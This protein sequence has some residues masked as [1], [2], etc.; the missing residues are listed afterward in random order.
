MNSIKHK[1]IG[2]FAAIAVASYTIVVPSELEKMI[3]N[4]NQQLSQASEAQQKITK[5]MDA[6]E[7]VRD[8]GGDVSKFSQEVGIDRPSALNQ[9]IDTAHIQKQNA[10]QLQKNIL[11]KL[12]NQK[13]QE[14]LYTPLLSQGPLNKEKTS[15]EQA[16]TNTQTDIAHE[17]NSYNTTLT[18]NA[19]FN[20]RDIKLAGSSA[21]P[22][23]GPI[24]PKMPFAKK[25]TT[26]PKTENSTNEFRWIPTWM[27]TGKQVLLT[28]A[29]AGAGYAAWKYI[30][31]AMRDR[32]SF[33]PPSKVPTNAQG[34]YLYTMRVTHGDW[35]YELSMPN[36]EIKVI[37][38]NMPAYYTQLRIMN[39]GVAEPIPVFNRL[40]TFIFDQKMFKGKDYAPDKAI[41]NFITNEDR[42]VGNDQ[43]EITIEGTLGV[44]TKF[45]VSPKTITFDPTN[46]Q[47]IDS[48]YK[49]FFEANFHPKRYAN[50]SETSAPVITKYNMA[51]AQTSIKKFT[52]LNLHDLKQ[53]FC[54]WYAKQNPKYS[55]D[56]K[57]DAL[58]QMEDQQ[59]FQFELYNIKK[60]NLHNQTTIEREIKRNTGILQQLFDSHTSREYEIRIQTPGCAILNE[61]SKCT[62]LFTQIPQKINYLL[63]RGYRLP[64]GDITAIINNIQRYR[65]AIVR[66]INNGTALR[67]I[68]DGFGAMVNYMNNL[69]PLVQNNQKAAWNVDLYLQYYFAYLQNNNVAIIDDM[70]NL[71]RSL[72]RQLNHPLLDQLWNALQNPGA[73]INFS[74]IQK[75]ITDLHLAVVNESPIKALLTS[76]GLEY[77]EKLHTNIVFPDSFIE[78]IATI[79]DPVTP[80][81]TKQEAIAGLLFDAYIWPLLATKSQ[82]GIP[83]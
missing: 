14:L 77:I 82:M 70:Q 43:T 68:Q 80:N 59:A 49:L 39:D 35:A 73:H 34:H 17:K 19:F 45:R 51:V 28:A 79:A 8:A 71:V 81:E 48:I 40:I 55:G 26:P 11:E 60:M 47:E 46:D 83:D 54:K 62:K 5:I 74:H 1:L 21:M 33:T 56:I 57:I 31:P 29:A 63:Q 61:L 10:L 78:H 13:Q 12:L 42:N 75:L 76:C 69:I 38:N 65:N 7:Q 23:S 58:V 30:I 18:R 25:V 37:H 15:I 4:I 44:P 20:A 2:L 16:L 3:T 50:V 36:E 32:I 27:P 53:Q 67:N 9:A 41:L 52:S 6:R 64:S 24:I 66:D 72:Y 22:L